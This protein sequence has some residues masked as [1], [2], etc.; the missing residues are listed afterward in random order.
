MQ[1][2]VRA[3]QP[4]TRESTR[5]YVPRTRPRYLARDAAMRFLPNAFFQRWFRR[6]YTMA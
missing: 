5:L 6:K 4:R 3:I 2:V 1:P